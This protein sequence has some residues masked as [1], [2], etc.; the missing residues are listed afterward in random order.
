M[1]RFRFPVLF[2][3][4][5]MLSMHAAAQSGETFS[6]YLTPS[7]SAELLSSKGSF[8]TDFL[9][10]ETGVSI[11]M[12]IPKNYDELVDNF[13]SQKTCFGM[14]NSQSYVIANSRHGAVV[15]LRTIRFGH[16][17]YQGMIITH[18]SSGIKSVR[19]IQGKIMAYTDELSTSG[20]LY[21]KKILE[22]NNVKPSK[23]SF[24]LKH[25]EVVRQVYERKVDAGAAFFSMPSANGA[26]NDARSRIKDKYPD[27]EQKVIILVKT[28]PIPND[29]IAFSKDFDPVVANKICMALL[30]LAQDA[31][32]KQ[33]L[34]DLYGAEGFVR[35]SDAD[36]N[37]IR[38]VM[39]AK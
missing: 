2:L 16:S 34:L 29:P 23:E 4:L 21:P 33:A 22:K 3:M 27:V 24:L 35:A 15:K 20:Y 11:E 1:I 13:K 5:L 32:G 30:K 10:K 9:K 12:K 25:D 19:D 39:G 31:K 7:M 38:Q 18:V 6:F 17:T 36:Y 28:D 26:I 37:S 14:M 8:I